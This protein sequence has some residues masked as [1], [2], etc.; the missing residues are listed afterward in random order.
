M[1]GD[2][3]ATSYDEV[4]Y[5]GGALPHT[6]VARL[7]AIG[8]LF[9]AHP[10]PAR[11]CRVLEV[12][13][14]IG[15]NLNTMA[16]TLPG[17]S[18]VG[19]DLSGRQVELARQAATDLGLANIEYRQLDIMDAGPDLGQFDY[20]IAYGVYSWV[21]PAVQARILDLCRERLRPDG[22]AF[23]SY[24]VYPGWHF[25]GAVREMLLYHTRR[26]VETVERAEQA[27]AFLEFMAT[28]VGAMTETRPHV[29]PLAAA[30]AYEQR[31][32]TERPD[33]YLVH[34]HL[35]DNNEPL[36]FREFARRVGAAGMQ[37]LGDAHVTTML[38]SG[39]PA[40]IT[41]V[42]GTVPMGEEF[43]QYRDFLVNRAFRESILCHTDVPV[44]RALEPD[45][46]AGLFI[47]TESQLVEPGDDR[48]DEGVAKVRTPNGS[49]LTLEAPEAMAAM[50]LMMARA[51]HGVAYEELVAAATEAA[52][53]DP[54]A[55]AAAVARTMLL[56]YGLDAVE[57]WSIEPDFPVEAGTRPVGFGPA[58]REASSS[59]SVT[60]AWHER[61]QLDVPAR[62]VLI[63]LDGTRSRTELRAILEQAMK[64]DPARAKLPPPDIEASLESTLGALGRAS[65]LEQS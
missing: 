8:R 63:A 22:L 27:R 33:F 5:D 53:Q 3:F 44:R 36:Y 47:R 60:N 41:R 52:P 49:V 58:R 12:A 51:P 45:G 38:A 13:C 26:F 46:L 37:Y 50:A 2:A 31:V 56:S 65:L 15:S 21:P 9:G 16:Y 23:V 18:F 54:T 14:G 1:T 40:D 17:S 25:R 29:A 6:H 59:G 32:V 34:E 11:E 4:P 39:L 64:A 55:A 30:L 42:M 10:A 7:E 24:N 62:A 28:S 43:E 57:T 35:E 20:V 61:V 48:F 19:I